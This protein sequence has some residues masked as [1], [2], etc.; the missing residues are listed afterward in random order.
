[1][2]LSGRTA[3]NALLG[4]PLLALCTLVSGIRGLMNTRYRFRSI[5]GL[6]FAG[7]GIFGG[8]AIFGWLLSGLP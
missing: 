2:L 7:A 3:F 5:F 6:I 8:V 4:I 1:M